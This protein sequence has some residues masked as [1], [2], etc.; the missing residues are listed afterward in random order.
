MEIT[1]QSITQLIEELDEKMQ[2]VTRERTDS[3]TC[4]ADAGGL[5]GSQDKIREYVDELIEEIEH[6]KKNKSGGNREK[7]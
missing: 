6:I 5:L 7:M 4:H 2:T 1:I 3:L